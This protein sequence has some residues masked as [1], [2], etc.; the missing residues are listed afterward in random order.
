[1]NGSIRNKNRLA[2]GNF[3]DRKILKNRFSIK[4]AAVQ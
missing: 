3:K 4:F 2:S 1:M